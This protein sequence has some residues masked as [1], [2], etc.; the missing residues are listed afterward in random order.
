MGRSAAEAGA[1]G[2]A[3]AAVAFAGVL[4]RAVFAGVA[5]AAVALPALRA[6][7]AFVAVLLALRAPVAF[8]A[9]LPAGVP[10]DE[11][12]AG[13]AG[14]AGVAVAVTHGAPGRAPAPLGR[15]GGPLR[16]SAK[17]PAACR[18]SRRRASTSRRSWRPPKVTA[19]CPVMRA[20]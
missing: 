10:V 18:A 7:V 1:A 4:A 16:K 12:S 6:P 8:V 9:A 15:P 14:S 2:A 5:L 19:T 13:E 20:F 11:G 3:G 17:L